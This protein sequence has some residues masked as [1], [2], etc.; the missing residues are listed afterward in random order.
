VSSVLFRNG[1]REEYRNSSLWF[2]LLATK[3]PLI[4]GRPCGESFPLFL[5]LLSLQAFV[6]MNEVVLVSIITGESRKMPISSKCVI[7]QAALV[8]VNQTEFLVIASSEGTQVWTVDGMELKFFLPIN[9]SAVTDPQG[10]PIVL[11]V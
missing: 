2:G 9:T 5:S 10:M 3:Q 4:L 6:R 11:F 1:V 8:N 7:Y